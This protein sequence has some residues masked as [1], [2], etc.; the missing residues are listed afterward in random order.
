MLRTSDPMK[1]T[2]ADAMTR[3]PM[4][5]GAEAV[6]SEALKLMEDRKITSLA[7]VEPDGKLAGVI[8]IHDLWRTE[9][10]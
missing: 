2:A 8:Q 4:T 9:L 1:G 3:D 5:I 7:V 10:F 6:A